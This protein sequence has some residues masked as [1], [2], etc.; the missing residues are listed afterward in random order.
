MEN[1]LY[2]Y[3]LSLSIDLK[4]Y[5][6]YLSVFGEIIMRTTSIYDVHTWAHMQLYK[7][8]KNE[9]TFTLIVIATHK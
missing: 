5:C 3:A 6:E 7:P 4:Y 1:I 2:I 8:H 9:H